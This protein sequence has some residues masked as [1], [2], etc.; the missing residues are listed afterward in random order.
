MQLKPETVSLAF[1]QE[2][3][4]RLSDVVAPGSLALDL[5]DT[6]NSTDAVGHHNMAINYLVGL[7]KALRE[8]HPRA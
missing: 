1:V 3:S 2:L 7:A 6:W 5:T 8:C 4:Q